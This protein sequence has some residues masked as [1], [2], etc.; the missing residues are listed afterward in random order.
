MFSLENDSEMETVRDVSDL[1]GDTLNIWGNDRGPW[2]L[3]K[4]GCFPMASLWT[5]QHFAGIH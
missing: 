5:H 2:Y 1:L 4:D 3:K